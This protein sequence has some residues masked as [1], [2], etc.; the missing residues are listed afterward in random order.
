MELPTKVIILPAMLEAWLKRLPAT[1]VKKIFP[2]VEIVPAD[3]LPV[4]TVK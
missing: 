4:V 3:K 1:A 2:S